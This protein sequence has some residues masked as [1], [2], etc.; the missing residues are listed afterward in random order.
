MSSRLPDPSLALVVTVLV[1]LAGCLTGTGLEFGD[2]D[3][4]GETTVPP[5]T[6]TVPSPSDPTVTATPGTKTPE[7]AQRTL[8]PQKEPW[9]PDP[10]GAGNVEVYVREYERTVRYNELLEPSVTEV[11]LACTAA[12]VATIDA[13][14][15]V[16]TA[17]DGSVHRRADGASSVS[18]FS[19]ER[20][21][22]FVNDSIVRRINS[23][24]SRVEPYRAEEDRS[25][26]AQP[27]G[28][29]IV[30]ADEQPHELRLTV[31]YDG[32]DGDDLVLSERYALA[33]SEGLRLRTVAARSGTYN[34]T[35]TVGNETT[36]AGN[37]TDAYHQRWKLTPEDRSSGNL[38]I[39]VTPEGDLFVVDMP[40][41]ER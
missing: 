31:R 3:Q 30:N 25:N 21:T 1:L 39:I 34:V 20:V 9:K 23:T 6:S 22:Y 33:S 10:I 37:E 18:R 14:Y 24:T 32:E 4:P 26:L 38:A 28:I 29:E 27:R 19:P 5:T 2:F 7:Q 11:N 8:A 15:V 41:L 16:R 13:G 35:A 17:C 12:L 36:Q 40:R